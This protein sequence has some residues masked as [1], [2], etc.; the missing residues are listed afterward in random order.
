MDNPEVDNRP[1]IVLNSTTTIDR[2]D[3]AYDPFSQFE[4]CEAPV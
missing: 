2:N 4:Q 1:T 3:F